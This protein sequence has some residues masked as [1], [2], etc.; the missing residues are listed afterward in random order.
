MVVITGFYVNLT[1]SVKLNS[2]Q[3]DQSPTVQDTIWETSVD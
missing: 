1:R 2:G 3:G